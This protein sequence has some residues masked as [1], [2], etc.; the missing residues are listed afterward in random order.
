M[1]LDIRLP[2][3]LMF[4]VMGALLA[5]FGLVAKNVDY[6]K[7]LGININ[8]WWGILL[9]LFGVVMFLV[10]RRGTSS[11]REA[12]ETVEGRKME[13]RDAQ[14]ENKPKRGGH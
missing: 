3:G 7:S 8:V 10:G 4:G 2:I 11:V 5:I 12:D 6:T 13:A 14:F 9:F 1:N